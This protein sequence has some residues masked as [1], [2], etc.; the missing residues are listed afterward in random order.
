MG[1]IMLGA[2]SHDKKAP[3]FQKYAYRVFC[4]LVPEG[5]F[6]FCTK[7]QRRDCCVAAQAGLVITMPAHSLVTVMIQV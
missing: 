2:S 4:R 6:S 1:P 7:A 5:E 3:M